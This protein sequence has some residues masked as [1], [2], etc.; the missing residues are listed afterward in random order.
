MTLRRFLGVVALAGGI[1]LCGGVAFSQT[2][3]GDKP[4]DKPKTPSEKAP[5]PGKPSEMKPGEAGG[6]GD[7]E[8]WMK[9]GMPGPNHDLLKDMVGTW[10]CSTKFWQGPDTE[11]AMSEATSVNTAMYGGRFIQQLY[12][13]K[14]SEMPMEGMGIVG[15]DNIKKKFVS[16]WMD[17]MGTSIAMS[18]GTYDPATK[19]F[20]YIGEFDDPSGKPV[21][22]RMTIKATSKDQHTFEMYNTPQG[23]KEFKMM[24]I[25][26]TRK[27]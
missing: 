21:K 12:T 8:A 27:S 24:E 6:H 17:S 7:M 18:Y 20:T 14:N 25:V 5:A 16:T 4:A 13:D 15:Y 10:K 3:P 11:P 22:N 9:V 26:Y 1:A 23:G 2:K 19:T